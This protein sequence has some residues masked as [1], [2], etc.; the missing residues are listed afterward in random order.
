MKGNT[1][2]CSSSTAQGQTQPDS[3][4]IREC[5]NEARSEDGETIEL[6]FAF[7]SPRE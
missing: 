5:V 2:P 4:T 3:F 7:T 1:E 6:I